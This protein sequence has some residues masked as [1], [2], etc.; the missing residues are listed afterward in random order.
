MPK[1]VL[2]EDEEGIRKNLT[3]LLRI[4]GYDVFSAP[5]GEAGVALVRAENPDLILCDVMMPILDGHGVLNALQAAPETA[6]IPFVFLTAM[7]DRNDFRAGMTLGADDYLTKPFT[8]EEVLQTVAARLRKNQSRRLETDVLHQSSERLQ[9]EVDQAQRLVANL[10]DP[11]LA[12]IPHLRC[13]LQ[14]KEI[15][16]GDLV[17]AHR[18]PNGDTVFMLGDATGHG[19][20]AAL[21]T[22]PVAKVF[23]EGIAGNAS[24][25]ELLDMLNRALKRLLPTG[26]Y[27]AAALIEAQPA[28]RRFIIW[29]GG[30]P[31]IKLF[32]PDGTYRGQAL[33]SNLPL[34]VIDSPE[35]VFDNFELPLGSRAYVFS[36][37]ITECQDESGV[38][39]GLP[40][41]RESIVANFDHE[42][43]L[44]LI[45]AT[46][47]LHQGAQAQHDDIALAELELR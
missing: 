33:S 15:A 25:P 28:T 11:R 19:L 2:I 38:L 43:R 42:N 12:E 10:V 9:Y 21:V 7:A 46:I 37:G 32:G 29:N 31:V 20:T 26:I 41:L 39:F 40:R 34:G 44:E 45:A 5:D 18:R 16:S 30:I 23:E 8:R 27:L 1:I 17:L 35:W 13:F 14:P 24:M 3:M 36:D 22:L 4:E 6:G 47:A